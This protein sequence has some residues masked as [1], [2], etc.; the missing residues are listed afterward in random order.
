M[1]ACWW[2]VASALP[3]NDGLVVL[4]TDLT[5]DLE[6]EG[7]ARDVVRQ[8]QEARKAA[9]LVVTD[10]I[11]LSLDLPPAVADAVRAHEQY[12]AD[13]VLATDVAYESPA[14]GTSTHPGSVSGDTITIALTVA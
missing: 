10:R 13:Q 2:V 6:A 8:V 1:P 12:V 7:L 14:T 3:G 5:P 4:D 11:E 9:D